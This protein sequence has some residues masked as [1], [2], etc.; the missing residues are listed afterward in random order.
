[1]ELRNYQVRAVDS[2]R[3]EVK[4]GRK[5]IVLVAPTGSG[6][7]IIV[8]D[9]IRSAEKKGS[10]VLFVAHRREILE[11]TSRKLSAIGVPHGWIMAGKEKS[12]YSQVQLASIQTLVRRNMPLADVV[13]WDE[14]HHNRAKSYDEVHKKFPDAVHIGLTATPCRTDGKGLGN[15]FQSLIQPVTYEELLTDGYLVPVVAYAPSIPDLTG[16]KVRGGDYVESEL[17]ESMNKPKLVG[18]LVSHWEKLAADRTTLVFAVTVAHALHIAEAFREAGHEFREIDGETE[19]EIRRETIQLLQ[20]RKIKGIVNVGLFTEG[21]DL[22]EVSCLVLARPTK[23]FGLYR[24]IVGRGLRPCTGKVDCLLLDH[25]GAIHNHGM[26]TTDVIW[27]LTTDEQAWKPTPKKEKNELVDWTCQSCGF[28]NAATRSPYCGKCGCRPVRFAKGLEVVDGELVRVGVTDETSE[29]H[30][31]T[32]DDKRAFYG[33]LKTI[34]SRHAYKS[35]WIMHKFR[36]RFGT[37]PNHPAIKNAPMLEPSI[38]TLN[39]IKHRQIAYAK[40]RRA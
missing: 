37:W 38:E 14:C 12:A 29:K 7:T 2:L 32:M 21:T 16:V 19:L 11:Q 6:K 20:N 17:G 18:D 28:V 15:I 36:E 25:S 22:P 27:E 33:E 30:I 34:A 24:Q 9:V 26:P 8:S 3:Q 5:N 4:N 13:V 40:R 35:G 31:F 39:F 10:R 23:S 1:M